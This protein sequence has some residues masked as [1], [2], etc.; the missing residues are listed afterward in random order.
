MI[1]C[2]ACRADNAQGPNCRRCKADLSML[3]SL[4]HEHESHLAA[5]VSAIRVGAP[6]PAIVHLDQAEKI[7]R[8][9][10][11]PQLRAVAELLRGRFAVAFG[12]YL[13]QNPAFLS[14]TRE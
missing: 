5:A 12:L 14:S 4:Q 7:R 2:P 13:Q 6:D 11:I 9:L 10:H 8:N 1:T 3:F